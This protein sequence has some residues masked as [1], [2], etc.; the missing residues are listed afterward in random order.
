FPQYSYSLMRIQVRSMGL[1]WSGFCEESRGICLRV[2]AMDKDRRQH[3]RLSIRL[4]VEC[5]PS[6]KDRQHSVRT[7]TNNI[8]TGGLY[9]EVDLI[10]GVTEP[11]PNSL[12]QVELTVPPGDGHVPYEGRL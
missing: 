12:L 6:K 2:A 8:S 7:V 3:R 10:E 1:Y 11:Q 9:F 5:C 4:P